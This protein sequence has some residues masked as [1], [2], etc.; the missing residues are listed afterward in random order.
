MSR[1]AVFGGTGY[2][3][4]LIKNQNNIKKN[5]YTFF[6]RK[7]GTKN[8]IN[9][10]SL[11]KNLGIFKN[12]DFIIHLAG[13]NQDQLKRNKRLIEKKN[14]ITSVLCDLC[15]AH[16]IKL[17]YISSMQIYK[18]Y[19]KKN[20]SINSKINLKNPY[21]KSHYDSEKIIIEKFLYYKKMFTILRVGNV[22][23]FTKCNNL[24]NIDNNLIHGLCNIALKK[25]IILIDNGHIQRTFIPSQIFVK[26]INSIIKKNF[27]DN[28]I[29][30][31]YYKNLILKVIAHIIQKRSKIVLNLTIDIII[32]KFSYN[33]DFSIYTNQNFKFNPIYKKIYNEIDQILKLI[34]KTKL[35]Y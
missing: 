17:I 11:K 23:G 12:F 21:S 24:K 9:F 26:V 4:S 28:M 25:K 27:F 29:I 14:K 20:I 34:K 16:N 8:Y 2:L 3:A 10:L 33:K 13:P 5:K 30:N 15:L 22:F 35:K 31:I 18:D 7:K 6:S 32:K 1:I 19:G